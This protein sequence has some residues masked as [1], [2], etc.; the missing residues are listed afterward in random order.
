MFKNK[1]FVGYLPAQYILTFDSVIYQD[2]MVDDNMSVLDK[3]L[4]KASFS[5]ALIQVLTLLDSLNSA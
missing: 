1:S 4:Q 3:N 5:L 2:V